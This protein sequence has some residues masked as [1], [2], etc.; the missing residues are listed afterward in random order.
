M[1]R[2]IVYDDISPT[3]AS[4]AV[5]SANSVQWFCDLKK[6]FRKRIEYKP[7][8]TCEHGQTILDG[9]FHEFNSI[10]DNYAF[11]SRAQSDSSGRFTTPIMLTI[12]FGGNLQSSVGITI[13]ADM[14][15]GTWPSHINIMWYRSGSVL[16]SVDFH[17]NS[18]NYAC[19]NVVKFYDA[20]RITFYSWSLPNH[21]LRLQRILFGI[22]REFGEG[23][24]EDLEVSEIIDLTCETL[25]I[26]SMACALNTPRISEFMLQKRQPLSTYWN[27]ILIGTHYLDEWER[28]SRTKISL[29]NIDLIGV[30]DS[31]SNFMGGMYDGKKAGDLIIEIIGDDEDLEI[32]SIVYDSLVYGWLPKL[33]R[34]DA[35]AH[36]AIAVGAVIDTSRSDMIRVKSLLSVERKKSVLQDRIYQGAK[37]KSG[38]TYTGVKVIQHDYSMSEERKELFKSEVS[39]KTTIEFQQPTYNL[40]IENGS[41]IEV[42]PNYSVITGGGGGET[43]VTGGMYLDSQQVIEVNDPL[44]LQNTQ[45]NIKEFNNLYLVGKRNGK[46]VANRLYEYYKGND[47][48]A[49]IIL[50]GEE[51]SDLIP[52][53]LHGNDMIEAQIEKMDLLLGKYKLRANATAR[54]REDD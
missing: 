36:I 10:E 54:Y 43:V 51:V 31:R 38:F 19:E 4:S 24:I 14:A 49:P 50:A 46:E 47:I 37:N 53:S 3:A 44:I 5:P 6:L 16:S 20:V 29:N 2:K 21:F 45:Q 35:L 52:I 34:R 18:P 1:S 42:H 11:W 13:M 23:E 15:G 7:T 22:T 30:T 28:Y 8:M 48:V 12:G 9:G 27:D 41:L 33:P 39:E 32:D 17:P 40:E 25:P 26:N